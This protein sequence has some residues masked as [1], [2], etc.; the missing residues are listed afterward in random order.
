MS[1]G[2]EFSDDYQAVSFIRWHQLTIHLKTHIS[3][4]SS[5]Q[6]L[7]IPF[8]HWPWNEK[9]L[10]YFLKIARNVLCTRLLILR[11][12]AA[13][14]VSCGQNTYLP[15]SIYS[16]ISLSAAVSS[17]QSVFDLSAV[18]TALVHFQN[19]HTN[20]AARIGEQQVASGL[21]V[22]LCFLV[23][24]DLRRKLRGNCSK[25][26]EKL[27]SLCFK[28]PLKVYLPSVTTSQ[29][30]AIFCPWPS[31]C[32]GGEDAPAR[33]MHHPTSLNVG[34][35]SVHRRG[36]WSRCGTWSAAQGPSG[37]HGWNR[38]RRQGMGGRPQGL[39]RQG[40]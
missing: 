32:P 4:S 9:V 14:Q 23:L 40:N 21:E 36:P 26:L 29:L 19:K 31:R 8:F 22:F 28:V 37:T 11:D 6:R 24:K 2:R 5:K 30:A 27:R 33:A 34:G 16:E 10:V 17:P 39:P 18:L 15:I 38:A 12:Q 3:V 35:C 1:D 13:L 7:T 20:P 25:L